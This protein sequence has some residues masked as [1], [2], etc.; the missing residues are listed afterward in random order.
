[1]ARVTPYGG[2]NKSLKMSRGTQIL[3]GRGNA[4]QLPENRGRGPV[5][6]NQVPPH[7]LHKPSQEGHRLGSR[8]DPRK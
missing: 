2:V 1:M 4:S 8:H 6:D 7:R 5:A 3:E